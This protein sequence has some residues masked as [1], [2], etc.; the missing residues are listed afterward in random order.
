MT[1]TAKSSRFNKNSSLFAIIV[2]IVLGV[3]AF[4]MFRPITDAEQVVQDD[5]EKYHHKPVVYEVAS[6]SRTPKQPINVEQL[7]SKLSTTA[8]TEQSL[9]FYGNHATKYRFSNKTEPP[10]YAVESE[11]VLEI[12]WY[13]AAPTDDEQQKNA[14]MTHAMKVYAV[15]GAYAGIQGETV[16]QN[17]LQNP[18]KVFH[19]EHAGIITAQCMHYQ[20][21]II[22]NK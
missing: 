17:A 7:K 15:M 12:A 14:S 18:N 11:D 21:R 3:M 9:D 2:A 22:L 1:D 13:Y 8:T 16:V 19:D 20:C 4:F 10:F 5:G 6:W